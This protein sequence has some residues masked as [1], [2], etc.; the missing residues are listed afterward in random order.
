MLVHKWEGLK[1]SS[2]HTQKV[3]QRI[4]QRSPRCC[5]YITLLDGKIKLSP[6]VIVDV[7]RAASANC[8]LRSPFTEAPLA[9][10]LRPVRGEFFCEGFMMLGGVAAAAA[11]ATATE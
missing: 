11:A 6:T 5:I 9:W 8:Y 10:L 4:R 2:T 3:Y 7:P 1:L